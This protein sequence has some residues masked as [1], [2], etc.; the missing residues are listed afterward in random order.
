MMEMLSFAVVRHINTNKFIYSMSRHGAIIGILFGLLCNVA[1]GSNLGG[2]PYFDVLQ[3]ASLT[4]VLP[5]EK[6]KPVS[7]APDT[8]SV[9]LIGTPLAQLPKHTGVDVTFINDIE[10]IPKAATFRFVFL[11]SKDSSVYSVV[12]L[13]SSSVPVSSSRGDVLSALASN[14]AFDAIA[15]LAAH[16]TDLECFKRQALVIATGPTSYANTAWMLLNNGTEAKFKETPLSM[17]AI[18]LNAIG[19]S[20][21]SLHSADWNNISSEGLNKD[22]ES[23][24]YSTG[25]RNAITL[26][27]GKNVSD[28]NANE[29]LTFALSQNGHFQA[30]VL[31][32]LSKHLSVSDL[33]H[34]DSL[35]QVSK[36]S[37]VRYACIKIIFQVL[38]NGEGIPTIDAFSE[39]P[40]EYIGRAKSMLERKY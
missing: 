29:L 36:N 33:D 4:I 37:W 8:F 7:V 6:L 27:I 20:V 17:L 3:N 18:G 30:D 12:N 13:L 28:D 1:N 5:V 31:L 34:V 14:D 22:G 21:L 16:E 35:L 39:A 23:D 26:W 11:E 40:D 25:L 2:F 15:K 24:F 10:P 38:N 19:I 32:L 9:M